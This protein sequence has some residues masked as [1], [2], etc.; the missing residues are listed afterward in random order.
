MRNIVLC[1]VALDTGGGKKFNPVLE[2]GITAGGKSTVAEI[3]AQILDVGFS[4]IQVTERTDDYAKEI[5]KKLK[6]AGVRVELDN[7]NET[8]G[9]KIREGRLRKAPYMVIVG[10]K[11]AEAGLV[12]PRSRE[13]GELPSVTVDEFIKT[14]DRECVRGGGEVL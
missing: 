6:K 1:L 4:R 3:C 9:Y 10:D 8:L 2:F 13:E 14:L 11:E 7:R 5:Y 12:A